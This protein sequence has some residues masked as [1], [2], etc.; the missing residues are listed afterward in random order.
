MLKRIPFFLAILSLTGG[1]F[2][3]ILFGANEDIF[4][5]KINQGLEKNLKIQSI[6][7]SE[8]KNIKL[9]EEADKNWRY[10]QR[11][12]FHA[13]GIGAMMLGLLIFTSGLFA[14]IKLK[15]I[16]QWLVSLGGFFYP[17]VWLFAALY[18]PEMGRSEAKES[19]ALF[20]YMGGFF[21]MGSLL[22]VY[23]SLKYDYK[24]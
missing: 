3:S 22:V 11:Y 24:E 7:D 18:G 13:T 8:Q 5:N 17:F 21:L 6:V 9:K 10:Y 12:H 23:M 16:S 19:F 4:K 14:P 15:L 2:I 1:V 20:G